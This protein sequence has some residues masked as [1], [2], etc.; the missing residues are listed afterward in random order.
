M[1]GIKTVRRAH[2]F[3][4]HLFLP[5][6]IHF[7]DLTHMQ[8]LYRKFDGVSISELGIQPKVV[9]GNGE[10]CPVLRQDVLDVQIRHFRAHIQSHVVFRHR[11]QCMVGAPTSMHAHFP[12]TPPLM[13]CC[14][15]SWSNQLP[16]EKAY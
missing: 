15:S 16:A 10:V 9:V 6:G 2:K 4:T 14:S 7:E 12:Q 11:G 1:F 8:C 13:S 5:D 3:T